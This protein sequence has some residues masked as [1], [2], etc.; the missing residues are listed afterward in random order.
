MTVPNV[1]VP[2]NGP[3]TLAQVADKGV[4][5]KIKCTMFLELMIVFS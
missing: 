4:L 2:L 5:V 1:D 3:D